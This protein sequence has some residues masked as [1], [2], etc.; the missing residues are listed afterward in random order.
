MAIRWDALCQQSVL[1]SV[2]ASIAYL[3]AL[4]TL[5]GNEVMCY[6]ISDEEEDVAGLAVFQRQR[7]PFL[8]TT[9]PF[10]TSFTPLLLKSL[11][12]TAQIHK[13]ATIFDA[14]LPAL[15]ADYDRVGLHLQ[16]GFTDMRTIAWHQW[17][18]KP[19]YTYRQALSDETTYTKAWSSSSRRTLKKGR[20]AYN[21]QED[22]HAVPQVVQLC[23]ASYERSR[24][25]AAFDLESTVA[26]IKSLQHAGLIRLFTATNVASGE[27]DAGVA[28]L[29]DGPK[30]HYWVAGSK[31][32]P[33]MTVLLGTALPIFYS[34]GFEEFDWVGANTP[35]IAEFKRRFGA[36][37]V[38]YFRIE[39]TPNRF[40]R[41]L[42]AIRS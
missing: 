7:G 25:A 5:G 13:R 11:P 1:P 34:E 18:S 14:L 23:T 32:G 24:G 12:T 3:N 22:E 28:F 33:A 21:V 26:F 38:P 4:R 42:E 40:L 36:E 39:R 37:L 16:P 29:L 15:S 20:S 6:V 8:E 9:I 41:I 19:L 35:S 27:V 31:P 2:Y 17:T 30:V 10:F